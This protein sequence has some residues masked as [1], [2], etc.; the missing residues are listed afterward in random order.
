MAK[1]HRSISGGFYQLAPCSTAIVTTHWQG[2]DNAMAAAWQT[3]LSVAPPLIGVSIAPNRFTSSQILGAKE[4]G[5]NFVSGKLVELVASVGGS[6]GK[7][8]DKFQQFKIVKEKSIATSVPILKE[9]YSAFECRLVDNRAYG[10]HIM[11]VGE[12]VAAHYLEEA[13]TPEGAV[14]LQKVSPPVYLGGDYYLELEKAGN[15]VVR[16]ERRT[17]G[18]K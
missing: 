12:I 8:I 4:F 17:Y 9:A 1:V 13:F 11:F 16:Y 5:V 2:K 10:D 14:D 7:N 15:A 18:K 3:T 6:T